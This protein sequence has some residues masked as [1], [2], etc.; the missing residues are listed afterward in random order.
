MRTTWYFFPWL[1]F[2]YSVAGWRDVGTHF[3]LLLMKEQEKWRETS[4]SKG[5]RGLSYYRVINNFI[6]IVLMC[7][8]YPE[9][10]R[11]MVMRL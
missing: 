10:S 6:I 11:C 2:Q 4:L 7:I 9:Q 1:L 3:K 5:G 8:K